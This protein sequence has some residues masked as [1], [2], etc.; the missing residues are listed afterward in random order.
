[1]QAA[2][3]LV[4]KTGWRRGANR[5]RDRLGRGLGLTPSRRRA[6]SAADGKPSLSVTAP[7]HTGDYDHGAR[8]ARRRA[9]S[10]CERAGRPGLSSPGPA[11]ARPARSRTGSLTALPPGKWTRD[12]CWRSPI[13]ARPRPS[14]ASGWTG[15]VLA[16]STLAPST[17]PGCGS[18]RSTGCAR[19]DRSLRQSFC[20][21]T[22]SGAC[23][24][25]RSSCP[26]SGPRQRRTA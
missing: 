3:S 11:P 18:P 10:G 19:G 13:P 15:W 6:H 4:V 1:M 26:R 2:R 9:E 14:L 5:G 23:G 17:P 16:G 21:T 25:T 20:R 22:R 24:E 7:R 8:R 12:S